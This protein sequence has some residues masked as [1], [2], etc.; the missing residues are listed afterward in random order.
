[1]RGLSCLPHTHQA[2]SFLI[3]EYFVLWYKDCPHIIVRSIFKLC[4]IKKE[5]LMN[6]GIAILKPTIPFQ[7]LSALSFSIG[8]V[9]EAH[10]FQIAKNPSCKVSVDLG[11]ALGRKWSIV[12]Q[13]SNVNELFNRTVVTVSNV[14]PCNI[15]GF[16]SEILIV[17]FADKEGRQQLLN[18]RGRNVLPGL[19]LYFEEESS[20]KPRISCKDLTAV[21]ARSAT[22]KSLRPL[23]TDPNS[24]SVLL[25]VG[26]FGE[27]TTTLIDIDEEIAK[28]IEGSQVLVVINLKRECRDDLSSLILSYREQTSGKLIPFGIDNKVENGAPL[29]DSSLIDLKAFL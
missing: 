24:Y 20:V 8:K 22:V 9:V 28:E 23:E 11:D 15:A 12:C 14:E 25:D 17:G 19:G 16:S 29:F 5:L 2:Y 13:D 4:N 6:V 21:D 27:R 10:P 3:S 7:K 1:M 26:N 18:T